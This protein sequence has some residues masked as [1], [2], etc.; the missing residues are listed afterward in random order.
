[1][2]DPRF[3]KLANVIIEHSTRLQKNEK[4][5]IEAIDIPEE[6]VAAL[7]RKIKSVGG[8]PLVTVKQNRVIRELYNVESE[9]AM[10]LAGEFEA[11]RMQKM[12]AYIA[13]RGSHNIAELSDVTDDG[14]KLYQQHWWHPVH[15]GV[16]VPHTKWVVLR[17]PSSSMAQQANMSTEAFEEFYFNVC[18]LDYGKMSTAMDALVARMEAAD[19]VHIK[20]AG[21]DLLFSIK[22]IPVVKCAGEKNVPDGEVYTAPVR[23]SVYGTLAYT[24]KTIYRGVVHEGIKLEFKDGKIINATSDKTEE[25][26]KVLDT[27]EGARYIGEFA[28][29][30]N[31]YITKPM[32][33]ILFDEKISGSFHF[34]PGGAYEDDADN[35]NRSKVHWDMVCIQTPEYGGGEIYFDGELI[36]KDGMFVAEDLKALN[37]ENLK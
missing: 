32:L 23:T 7:L 9:E 3:D 14:M 24:A 17:W 18:T 6:M 11:A 19:Q 21:T 31:P 37:P 22:D 2:K 1:M 20:G 28:L 8:V 15:I 13:L 4:I 25:L 33:D 36:R 16:R 26:N 30:V 29:G 27:D 5:L 34:T 10:Q 35:G 12:D